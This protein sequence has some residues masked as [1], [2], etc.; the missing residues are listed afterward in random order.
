[1]AKEMKIQFDKLDYQI[2]AINSTIDVF[3]GQESCKSNFT[4]LAPT[5]IDGSYSNL[6]SELGYANKLNLSHEQLLQNTQEIQLRNGLR[7]SKSDEVDRNALDFSVEMETGTGKTYVFLRSI[8]EMNKLYGFTKFIIVVPSIPIKEGTNKNLEMTN[9]KFKEDFDN[10]PYSYFVYD[11]GNLSKVRDFAVS[12]QLRIMVINIQAFARDMDSESKT[13]RILLE[14]NDKLG[15]TPINL[16][17]ETNPIII[18]DE[19]QSTLSTSLQKKSVQNL[20]PLAIFRYSAT[21][22]EKINLLYRLNAVDAYQNKLVKQIE[23][24]SVGAEGA[25]TDG[26]Y[27]KLVSVTN[28]KNTISAK[29]ELDALVKGKSQR[30]VVEVKQNHQLYDISGLQQYDDFIVQNIYVAD[31]YIEFSNGK[32]LGVGEVIGGVDD[33][34]I[35]RLQIQK[36]IEEHLDKE[37]DLNPQGIKVLSLFFIDSVK[38]YRVYDE[39]GNASN[40]IYAQIF[41]EEYLKSIK[42]RKYESLFKEVRDIESEVSTIHN[43]YFSIDK[44]SKKSDKKQKF[45]IYKDTQGTTKADEDTYNLIMKDK[46]KLLSFD[47]KLRFIFSHS[48]LKEGWDNP[49]VFQIC[50]LKEAGSSEINRRQEIGRGLRLCVN[51]AGERVY[52]HG[53][54]LLTV[55]A[56]ESYED[57]VKG[58]QKEVEK[59]IGVKFGYLEEHSFNNIVTEMAGDTPIYL[60]EEQSKQLY[61]HLFTQMYI[62]K[63]GKV[64]DSLRQALLD[65]NVDL[66]SEFPE[67]IEKQIL[68]TIRETAGRLEIKNNS[69]KKKVQIRKEVYLSNDFKELWDRIKYKTT[70]QVNFDSSELINK[71]IENIDE[72]L[73]VHK[74]NVVYRKGTLDIN[75]GGVESKDEQIS[76]SRLDVEVNSLPDIITYLQNETNLTRRSIV[77]ILTGISKDRLNLFKINPQKF[78]ESCIAIINEQMRLHIVDG[79]KYTKIG[80][81]AVYEQE[82]YQNEELLGYLNSNMVEA[83]KSI[84]EHIVY[85]SLV[86]KHLAEQFEKSEN[87][88]LYAKLPSW[89]KVDTPLGSY[90]PDWAVLYTLGSVEKLYFVVESKGSMFEESLRRSESGKIKCGEKHFEE[91]GSKLFTVSNINEL[92]D[93]IL[94]D[95]QV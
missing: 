73:T 93:K 15:A 18:V 29:L 16:I 77:N 39:E 88:K 10:V 2:D 64:E 22:R 36:T 57:F 72:K 11:S 56:S 41:E 25:A 8:L 53:V 59:E 94:S 40:G 34:L 87:V 71:C 38:N 35:K 70:F 86:E 79:I 45:E 51:Q 76:V 23:V 17:K 67:H 20:N 83:K 48:A 6:Q 75:T 66:G 5:S 63:D 13:K 32:E 28:K 46:E 68:N 61:D 82:L 26:A 21:H 14:Y 92:N 33:L 4:V 54:N 60:G 37:V 74:G 30:K 1:M 52:G 65:S 50:T 78:I 3:K 62:T 24:S 81:S 12:D 80:E 9:D 91:L 31:Q 43:G 42:K 27:L 55:M 89:F 7:V 84:Y 90:N 69:D 49:N 58:F 47:S 44:A 19:P 85:D 95:K